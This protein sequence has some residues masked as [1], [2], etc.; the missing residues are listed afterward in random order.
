[1]KKFKILLILFMFTISC[2]YQPILTSDNKN[3][4]FK[5]AETNGDDRLSF[6][7]IR[8]L[9]HLKSSDSEYNIKI[10]IKE[11]KSISSK[12]KKGNP[13]IFNLMI[14]IKID[15]EGKNKNLSQTFSENLN[16]NNQKNKF[17]L[18]K[19]ENEIKLSLTDKLSQNILF[20]LQSV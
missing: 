7:V 10:D 11:K 16:Y 12:D 8:N 6:R 18:K 3:F 4:S 14:I 9:E 20:Y 5:Q 13:S 1:M 17:D 15:I 19:F 2:G